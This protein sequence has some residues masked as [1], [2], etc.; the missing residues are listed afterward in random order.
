MKFSS[1]SSNCR[2]DP[3]NIYCYQALH[4]PVVSPT[5]FIDGFRE[6]QMNFKYGPF[7]WVSKTDSFWIAMGYRTL[8]ATAAQLL[9]DK[10]LNASWVC[11]FKPKVVDTKENASYIS[12]RPPV[13]GWVPNANTYGFFGTYRRK[14]PWALAGNLRFRRHMQEV[15]TAAAA[16][17]Y[18]AHHPKGEGM[19]EAWLC[20][21]HQTWQSS[22]SRKRDSYFLLIYTKKCSFLQ[23]QQ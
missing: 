7:W 17:M 21:I 10:L 2:P 8:I 5:E 13:F 3:A 16:S 20:V 19:A 23:P 18:R 9:S 14:T 22:C 4:V 6:A 12:S 15:G 11:A 1:T